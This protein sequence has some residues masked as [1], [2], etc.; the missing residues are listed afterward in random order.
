METREADVPGKPLV[1]RSPFWDWIRSNVGPLGV[2]VPLVLAVIAG[3]WALYLHFAG[4]GGSQIVLTLKEYEEALER[5]KKRTRAEIEHVD[6][7]LVTQKDIVVTKEEA[8]RI[9]SRKNET[10]GTASSGAETKEASSPKSETKETTSSRDETKGTTQLL[11]VGVVTDAKLWPRA[12]VPFAIDADLPRQHINE[13]RRAVAHVEEKTV[14]RFVERTSNNASKHPD[15]AQFKSGAGCWSQVGV[16]GGKQEVGLGPGCSFGVIVHQ[17]GHVI[18]LQHEH[19]RSDRD[20]YVRIVWDNV[21]P[22]L[23][24]NFEI[25][26]S[27][28]DGL[29]AYDYDSIIHYP[30]TAFSGNGNPTIVPLRA[31]RD[32]GQRATLSGGDILLINRLYRQ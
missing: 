3:T 6:N 15:Y 28:R 20:S 1:A 25:R 12:T 2:I 24:H 29:R 4:S 8:R 14:I 32:I 18:G 9:T 11:P 7:R 26:F 10:R 19:N 17:L 22:G 31:N 21:T 13:L 27:A 30:A 16:A 5:E 23:E